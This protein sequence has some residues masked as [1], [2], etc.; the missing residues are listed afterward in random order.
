LWAAE[1]DLATGDP[2]TAL[3]LVNRVRA[4]AADPKGWVYAGGAA[5]SAASGTYAPQTTPAAKYKVG[6]YPAGAFADPVYA[7]KAI[8]FERR[9]ELSMEGQRFF[10]LVRWGVAAPVLN[11]Y[12]AHEQSVIPYLKG[13]KFTA[14]KSE[15]FPIPQSQIDAV[16]ASG[17]VYLKQN[18]G[19]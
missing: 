2:A 18:P 10:D 3:T 14:G 12:V 5:Y 7:L 16:N 9:L 15:Y 8:I 11:T 17:T 1:A 4:R 19:Y 6:L 13:A